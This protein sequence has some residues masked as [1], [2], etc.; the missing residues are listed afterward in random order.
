MKPVEDDNK[1]KQMAGCILSY[2]NDIEEYV[3]NWADKT[4]QRA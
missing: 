3:Y 4:K 1:K 2:Q